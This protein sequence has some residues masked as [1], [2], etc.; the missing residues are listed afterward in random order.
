MLSLYAV[1]D[2]AWLN[3]RDLAEDVESALL[4][5][6]TCVQLREKDP[7]TSAFIKEA[8]CLKTLCDAYEIPLIINDNVNIAMQIGA[9]GIHIGQNDMPADKARALIGPDMILGVSA[10]T[11]KQALD[12]QAAGADYLGVGAV[13]P[14][15][16]K[17]DADNVS[18]DILKQICEAVSIPVVAIGGINKENLPLLSDT[19]IDGVAVVSAIFA[20]PDIEKAASDLKHA[21]ST[22]IRPA[23]KGAIFDLDGTLLDS[24]GYWHKAPLLYL[25]SLGIRAKQE[26]A[27]F[28]FSMTLPEACK[29]LIDCFGLNKTLDDVAE[30]I[31]IMMERFYLRD[32]DI[33]PGVAAMLD[34]L[35][36]RNIPCIVAT[37]TDAPLA[38][39]A[40]NR[41]GI[42]E[43][44]ED[45]VTVADVGRGKLFP[46]V[47]V[48]A[49]QIIGTK[50][51]QT[52]VFED[53]PHALNT[54]SKAGF[55]TVG[56]FDNRGKKHEDAVKEKSDYFLAT[57]EQPQEIL[58]L[59]DI[60]DRS[61]S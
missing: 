11:V 20:Q 46:D 54:A 34:S 12:A 30:E 27:E 25:E 18:L 52:L 47:Y 59:I 43:Y 17:P 2:R 39:A 58:D 55:V 14:T 56:V 10:Q 28:I 16:T 60:E 7:D 45:V 5:G 48:R 33:K 35:K 38:K 51:K 6:V 9:A 26:T 1:T 57:F 21:V 42:L 32:I 49:A 3:G 50:P 22:L 23:I 41:H 29:Y 31:N 4:G 8:R 40:L 19:G 37:V 44:F 36:Q 15:G 61:F 24:I 53:A 13:F